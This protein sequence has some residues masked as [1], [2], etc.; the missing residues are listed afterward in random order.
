VSRDRDLELQYGAD[1]A[2]LPAALRSAFV[3]LDADDSTRSW[4]D[5]ALARPR[6]RAR[7]A[8]RTLAMA[9]VNVYDANG[10][11]NIC[12]DRLLS[13]AQWRRL[14]E[15][16]ARSPGETRSR[17]LDVGA[18]DGSVTQELAALFDE[19]VTTEL[20][21]PMARRLR[22]K[23]YRCHQRDLSFEPIDET[24]PFDAI[25]LQNVIDRASHP[26][27][28]L[29][30]ACDLLAEHGRLI[31][32]VP[33]P[34]LPVVFKGP[35][36]L[37]PAEGLPAGLPDFEAS[38]SALQ[39]RVFA[40]RGWRVVALARAPYLCNGSAHAA[41]EALDAAIFVLRRN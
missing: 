16:G 9:V 27:Q 4:I 2:R 24:D 19:I 25:A 26:L 39:E 1:L 10:W 20:S 7:I 32:T 33:V 37:A 31:V 12:Q 13:T 11:T 8:L 18:G 41:V 22:S 35:M 29:D 36:R 28:L 3:E 21:K 38:V 6:P 5:A 34:I 30:R 14:L 40:A 17:L 15:A 23:G